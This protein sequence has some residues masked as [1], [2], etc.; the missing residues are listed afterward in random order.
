MV[1][2]LTLRNI[3]REEFKFTKYNFIDGLHCNKI[4][5]KVFCQSVLI[6]HHLE[7]LAVILLGT[8]TSIDTVHKFRKNWFILLILGFYRKDILKIKLFLLP[9]NS[10]QRAGLEELRGICMHTHFHTVTHKHTHT[11]T[12]IV[13]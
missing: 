11:V 4:Q 1:V 13:R 3:N 6:S 12:Q 8:P 5:M 9:V 7:Y 10:K 2:N